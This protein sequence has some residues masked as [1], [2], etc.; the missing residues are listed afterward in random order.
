MLACEKMEQSVRWQFLCLKK[1]WTKGALWETRFVQ[2]QGNMVRSV[3]QGFSSFARSTDGALAVLE[4]EPVGG[5]SRKR[6]RWCITRC[7]RR[8]KT[9]EGWHQR[10]RSLQWWAHT[11]LTFCSTTAHAMP[12]MHPSSVAQL[13]V[14]ISHPDVK[15][16]GDIFATM[17]GFGQQVEIAFK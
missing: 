1:R 7:R 16:H 6:L 17:P 9:Q 14:R 13:L 15:Q 8:Q 4:L 2:L 3:D 11:W 5:H 12:C 10:T